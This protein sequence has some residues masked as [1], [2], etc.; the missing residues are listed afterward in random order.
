MIKNSQSRRIAA[1][2]L[3]FVLIICMFSGCTA[4]PKLSELF[5]KTSQETTEGTEESTEETRPSETE[6]SSPKTESDT[7]K[8]STEPETDASEEASSASETEDLEIPLERLLFGDPVEGAF[9]MYHVK[10]FSEQ[11]PEGAAATNLA[12]TEREAVLSFV[13]SGTLYA[14]IFDYGTQGFSIYNLGIPVSMM[15]MPDYETGSEVQLGYESKVILPCGA[16]Y[17]YRFVNEIR[18]YD[19]SFQLCSTH[20]TRTD[21][22]FV[23]DGYAADFDGTVLTLYEPDGTIRTKDFPG[24]RSGYVS[25][26][27]AG[28]ILLSGADEYRNHRYLE[29]DPESFDSE[30]SGVVP[31]SS[32]YREGLWYRRE[33]NGRCIV[34]S[35]DS[36]GRGF[37]YLLRENEYPVMRYRDGF[38]TSIYSYDFDADQSTATISFYRKNSLSPVWEAELVSR[39]NLWIEDIVEIGSCLVYSPNP[40]SDR[41]DL[42]IMEVSD[43]LPGAGKPEYV[44]LS[45]GEGSGISM[46]GDPDFYSRKR[47]E[48]ATEVWT[49]YNEYG[50]GIYLNEQ[51]L[52]KEFPNYEIRSFADGTVV[53]EAE[54]VLREFLS[55]LPEGFLDDAI[56][57]YGGLD[58]YLVDDIYP[59]GSE[60]IASV[61]AFAIEVDNRYCIVAD[62]NLYGLYRTFPHE[63]MHMLENSMNRMSADGNAFPE[64]NTLN[65][66]GFSYYQS[67][68]DANGDEYNDSN[69]PAYTP[70]DEQSYYNAENIYFLDAYSKTYPNED[71]ARVFEFACTDDYPYMQAYDSSHVLAKLQTISDSLRAYF[72]SLS[73]QQDV[74]WERALQP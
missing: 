45:D 39:D 57:C 58:F 5:P 21:E 37:L 9:R 11:I 68:H 67:Y 41:P 12:V 55:G 51:A 74:I 60:G 62:V 65:P 54:S 52:L 7:D 44:R 27:T 61:A 31:Y 19:R 13:L 33:E 3:A 49:E 63:F 26:E 10:G 15:T 36:P 46:V 70:A 16:Y 6:Q 25:G 28:G 8:P 32:G 69:Y 35:E 23:F 38:L 71:R 59:T 34:S 4:L 72:P 56:R 22:A 24:L 14:G 40:S 2:L 1:F 30:M 18:F 48:D 66:G 29:V 50:V 47:Y 73:G 43:L 20:Q 53:G 42:V 64:W 17:V